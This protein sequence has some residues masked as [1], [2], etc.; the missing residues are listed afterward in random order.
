MRHLMSIRVLTYLTVLFWEEYRKFGF[1][2][3]QNH[4]TA[5]VWF[6][7]WQITG[8]RA[9]VLILTFA[10]GCVTGWLVGI[11]QKKVRR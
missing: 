3:I 2:V 5:K 1:F 10:I 6:L 7:F 11:Q 9:A 8:S 4:E